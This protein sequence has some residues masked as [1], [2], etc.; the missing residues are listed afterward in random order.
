MDQHGRLGVGEKSLD[1]PRCQPVVH[2]RQGC[3]EQ[4]G[5]EHRLE[6]RRMVRAEP[7]HPVTAPHAEPVQAVRQAA[8][9]AGEFR[10]RE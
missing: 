2:R 10:V 6:E 8:N 9:A 1:I 5:G 3:T 4:A 7:G